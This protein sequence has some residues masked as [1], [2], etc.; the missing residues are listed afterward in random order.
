MYKKITNRGIIGI[1]SISKNIMRRIKVDDP[2]YNTWGK[3]F[4]EYISF[5]IFFMFYLK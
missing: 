2:K 3:N 1:N 4:T 5:S